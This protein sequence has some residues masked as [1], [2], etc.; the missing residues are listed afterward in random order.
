M[1]VSYKIAGVDVTVEEINIKLGEISVGVEISAEEMVTQVKNFK[2]IVTFLREEIP[3]WLELLK[4]TAID[5][6][7]KAARY[8]E[9][10][11]Y[12]MDKEKVESV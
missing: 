4:H 7:I 5:K 12:E 3:E 11:S 1:K 9:G 10:E 6:A 8:D 2:E